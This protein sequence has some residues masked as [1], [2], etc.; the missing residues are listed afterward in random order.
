MGCYWLFWRT[1]TIVEMLMVWWLLCQE[2]GPAQS[3]SH[4]KS[5]WIWWDY[6]TLDIQIITSWSSCLVR[7]VFGASKIILTIDRIHVSMTW[8]ACKGGEELGISNLETLQ[9]LDQHGVTKEPFLPRRKPTWQWKI[10]IFNRGYILN[11]LFFYCYVCFLG[12][13]ISESRFVAGRNN[14][15][16]LNHTYTPWD[17][18]LPLASAF[19]KG[20]DRLSTFQPSIFRCKV[21]VSGRV[22]LAIFMVHR[23]NLHHTLDPTNPKASAL[24][25]VNSK[26]VLRLQLV[27]T[28][29]N[30]L[31]VP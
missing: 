29:W 23:Y 3:G 2:L 6:S 21:F 4:I 17:E 31:C 26:T 13:N 28:S 1:S 30:K 24:A 22:S 14:L 7:F 8:Y 27:R 16:G 15:P 12:S 5:E 19:L 20:S 18:H 10:S 25:L 9:L 11:V